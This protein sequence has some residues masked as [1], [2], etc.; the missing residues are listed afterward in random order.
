MNNKLILGT[1]QLGLNYG[2]NNSIGKPTE[3]QIFEILD[4]ACEKNIESLDTADAYGD[5]IERIGHY[6]KNSNQRFKILSKFKFVDNLSLID[7]VNFS[8]EK[9]KIPYFEVY[10]Y[11]SCSDYVDHP[12]LKY[13]L[14]LLKSKGLIKK[15]GI[16]VYTNEEL[17]N[18]IHDSDIDVIQIPYNILDNN[19]LRGMYIA[20]A[21]S[22][23]KEIH[24]R[25]I[26]LQGLFFME[27][28]IIPKKLE[29]LN[30]YIRQIKEYCNN[31]SINLLS[32]AI[33][34]PIFNNCIDKVLIGVDN[35]EHL[36]KNL[37]SFSDLKDAFAYI[38]QNIV[39]KEIEL[40]N[41]V[42]WK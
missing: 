18:V 25:S 5:A 3:K 41:P 2:I 24:V 7:H 15:T 30:L 11:H 20:E 33:S 42:N 35:K 13:K 16:S 40:L 29:A 34:Y 21:K 28:N 9:L 12:D 37:Q 19:N 31:E 17:S 8:L 23:N 22:R 1:A 10:S 27:D 36:L 6:H 4:L 26:F 39:V 38:N 14:C 32:L